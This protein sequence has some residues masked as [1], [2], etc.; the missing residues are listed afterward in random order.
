MARELRLSALQVALRMA[1]ADG[2]PVLVTKA[3]QR[4]FKIVQRQETEERA[5]ELLIDNGS[6]D[7]SEFS[8]VIDHDIVLGHECDDVVAIDQ[9]SAGAMIE[10]STTRKKKKRLK[11]RAKLPHYLQPTRNLSPRSDFVTNPLLAKALVR[12]V[13]LAHAGARK[14]RAISEHEQ[15]QAAR[16]GADHCATAPKVRKKVR[17]KAPRQTKKAA[18]ARRT[19]ESH[20]S[21]PGE[22]PGFSASILLEAD[23]MSLDSG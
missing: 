10:Q 7:G 8:V 23:R 5:A 16:L 21:V 18:A 11:K 20:K 15:L 22:H 4:A 1:A 19:V 12:R 3:L 6:D 9:V 13:E 17:A 2:A 14:L